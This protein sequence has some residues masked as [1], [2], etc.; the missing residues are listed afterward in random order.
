MN[1]APEP[2]AAVV[3]GRDVVIID[4]PHAPL[5]MT[6]QLIAAQMMGAREALIMETIMFGRPGRHN[7]GLLGDD[8]MTNTVPNPATSWEGKSPEQILSEVEALLRDMPPRPDE[9]EVSA[10][11]YQALIDLN[12][13]GFTIRSNRPPLFAIPIKVKGKRGQ[14]RDRAKARRK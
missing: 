6:R 7:R 2:P 9:M 4:D 11:A 10:S 8:V 14:R 12:G 3:H 5:E 1:D 13:P